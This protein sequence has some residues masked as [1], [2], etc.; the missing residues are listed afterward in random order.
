MDQSV[1]LRRQLE[2]CQTNGKLYQYR[3]KTFRAA[4]AIIIL[5]LLFYFSG[6]SGSRSSKLM[7]K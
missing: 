3:E 2:L 1:K 7:S 6:Y 5:L 4:V